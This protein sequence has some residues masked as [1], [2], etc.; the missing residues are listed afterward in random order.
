MRFLT[1]SRIARVSN[2]N[3]GHDT[4]G[5]KWSWPQVAEAFKDPQM[6]FSFL[7]AFLNNVPNGYVR[8]ILLILR[9]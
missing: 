8:S 4:T 9:T 6:W 1:P 5:M 7:N 2:N 3:A